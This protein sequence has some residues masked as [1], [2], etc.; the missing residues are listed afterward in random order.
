MRIS[1]IFTIFFYRFY[2]TLPLQ[3]LKDLPMSSSQI[4][5]L[6]IF[7]F[8]YSPLSPST[9]ACMCTCV[10]PSTGA[11]ITSEGHTSTVMDSLSCKRCQLLRALRLSDSGETSPAPLLSMLDGW[12]FKHFYFR[13]LISNNC[14]KCSWIRSGH[15]ASVTRRGD[16][17]YHNSPFP[18]WKGLSETWIPEQCRAIGGS[19]TYLERKIL[20]HLTLPCN[21]KELRSPPDLGL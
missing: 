12:I 16:V 9:V 3:V 10:E 13:I 11:W 2:P 17:K 20:S 15:Q 5:N 7:L 4:H 19:I 18:N 21:T 1:H 14:F 8:L 6:F